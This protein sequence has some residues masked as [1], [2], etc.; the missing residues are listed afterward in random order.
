VGNVGDGGDDRAALGEQGTNSRKQ[1]ARLSQVLQD[2]GE[3]D[4]IELGVP[5]ELTEVETLGISDDDPLTALARKPA[6]L[7]RKL[8][9]GD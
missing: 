6:G 3:Q 5:K 8:N 7:R 4:G 2:I 1:S 9:A